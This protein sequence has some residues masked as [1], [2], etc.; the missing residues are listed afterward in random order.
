M[1]EKFGIPEILF[2]KT[3]NQ[4]V[5]SQPGLTLLIDTR[6]RPN[7]YTTQC[8]N[9]TINLPYKLRAVTSISLAGANMNDAM[10]NNVSKVYNNN[11]FWIRAYGPD[12]NSEL[13]K[14]AQPTQYEEI[15]VHL[16]DGHFS[17][18]DAISMINSFLQ[19]NTT[20]NYLQYIYLTNNTGYGSSGS[21]QMIFAIST[22]YYTDHNLGPSAEVISSTPNFTFELDFQSDTNGNPDY[23][24]PLPS[25]LG[26]ALGF[27]NGTYINNSSY[28][29]ESTPTGLGPR[30]FYVCLDDNQINYTVSTM[31]AFSGS[32]VPGNLLGTINVPSTRDS[33]SNIQSFL[34]V[35][36][37][38]SY[39][40]P[41]D[42]EKLTIQIKDEF[43]R[44]SPGYNVDMTITLSASFG[45]L[46]SQGSSSSSSS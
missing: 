36:G 46:G 31:N 27:R 33:V 3:I 16:T 38:R 19:S 14:T 12:Y 32:M 37:S 45:S 35:S 22:K 7:Y 28:L 18:N 29:S 17:T 13:D 39:S 11:F 1:K 2:P 24:T 23:Y 40:G 25:K 44:I 10:F 41:V 4:P 6:F 21:T 15:Q 43:G 42:L 26:W 5:S 30:Y 20:S 8:T 9:F 34:T